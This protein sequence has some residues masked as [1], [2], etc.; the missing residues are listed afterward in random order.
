LEAH[1]WWALYPESS[2]ANIRGMRFCSVW[3]Q[4][5]WRTAARLKDSSS[6]CQ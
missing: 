5:S 3:V 4:A 1:W 6:V 2:I